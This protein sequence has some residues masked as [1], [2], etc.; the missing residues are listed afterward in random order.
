MA[1]NFS[2][3][4]TTSAETAYTEKCRTAKGHWKEEE[5]DLTDNTRTIILGAGLINITVSPF[6]FFIAVSLV[7]VATKSPMYRPTVSKYMLLSLVVSDLFIGCIGQ[8]TYGAKL[9]LLSKGRHNCSLTIISAYVSAIF[10]TISVVTTVLIAAERYIKI[11]HLPKYD[12]FC[13]PKATMIEVSVLWICMITLGIFTLG[14]TGIFSR[15]V[16]SVI[17]F[18]YIFNIY[19]YFRIL[20]FVRKVSFTSANVQP[21]QKNSPEGNASKQAEPDI[22]NRNQNTCIK[23]D[24]RT[25]YDRSNGPPK[26]IVIENNAKVTA[27]CN[28][29]SEND[30]GE[31]E[32]SQRTSRGLCYGRKDTKENSSPT[33]AQSNSFEGSQADNSSN[34]LRQ[35]SNFKYSAAD[36]SCKSNGLRSASSKNNSG[37]PS[38]TRSLQENGSKELGETMKRNI[39]TTKSNA[40]VAFFLLFIYLFSFIR[41][42]LVSRFPK[43][44]TVLHLTKFYLDTIILLHS[45][46]NP[47][48][49]FYQN[50]VLLQ[51]FKNLCFGH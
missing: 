4:N 45:V 40:I 35:S 33:R 17:A 23:G 13:S 44:N 29:N 15:I 31:S 14:Q 30:G 27:D 9:I 38:T 5:Y 10:N 42:G 3:Y 51:K 47:V 6:T 36:N 18:A 49:I 50:R 39:E 34:L 2:L 16:P 22:L 43:R 11:F 48:L 41:H 32:T 12:R 28:Q 8:P 26:I 37:E 24:K 1:F 21:S 19:V 46:E 25:N 20:I 7:I